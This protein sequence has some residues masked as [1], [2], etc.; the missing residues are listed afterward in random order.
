MRQDLFL[1]FT[2]HGIKRDTI[3]KLF[4]INYM[5]PKVQTSDDEI[6]KGMFANT[7]RLKHS[8]IITMQNMLNNYAQKKTRTTFCHCE[9]CF[10]VSHRL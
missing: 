8:N 4:P 3:I 1:K 10:S 5:N 9:L 6:Y 7:E 2:K